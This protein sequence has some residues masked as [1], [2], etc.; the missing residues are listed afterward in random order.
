MAAGFLVAALRLLDELRPSDYSEPRETYL[1]K[2]LRGV[3][4]DDFSQDVARLALTLADVPNPNG[5]TLNIAD[6]F[7]GNLL[8]E[9]ASNAD[10]VLANPPFEKL[11][12]K[13]R[14]AGSLVNKAAEIFR[15]TIENL[16]PNGIF[17]FVLPQGFLTSKEATDCRR[18]IQKHCEI[19]EITLFADKVFQYGEPESAIILGQKKNV[20]SHSCVRYQR[21]RESQVDSFKLTLTPSSCENVNQSELCTEK[22]RTLF[23]VPELRE[24]WGPF[25]G[26]S[27]T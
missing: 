18:Y 6:V 12:A 27:T 3:D 13:D 23:A 17:G 19:H 8:A 1:R 22:G 25:K 14:T 16:A 24:V 10:I 4:V 15:R 9:E 26:F 21:V 11:T 20:E 2:R 5:W 7:K